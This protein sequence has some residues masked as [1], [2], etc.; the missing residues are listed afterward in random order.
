MLGASEDGVRPRDCRLVELQVRPDAPA[1]LDFVTL[2]QERWPNRAAHED[3]IVPVVEGRDRRRSDRHTPSLM[4][5]GGDRDGRSRRFAH[6]D[7]ATDACPRRR[8]TISG[9]RISLPTYL[10]RPTPCDFAQ[11]AR[12][13]CATC[14]SGVRYAGGV[15]RGASFGKYRL[16]AELG[17]GGMADVFLAIQAGPAGSNFR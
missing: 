4:A 15:M 6:G 5:V 17:H 3:E 14:A 16:I 8:V 9:A 11:Y 12:G 13:L 1:N 7:H 10:H 2:D